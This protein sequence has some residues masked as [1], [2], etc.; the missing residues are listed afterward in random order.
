MKRPR[1]YVSIVNWKQPEATIVCLQSLTQLHQQGVRVV[2][3]DNDSRDNSAVQIRAAFPDLTLL[4]APTNLGFAGG[5]QLA[6]DEVILADA[7][8]DLVWLLN[9]DTQVY[10]NTL[11][12]LIAAY[13]QHGDAVYG[14][15]GLQMDDPT[16]IEHITGH[17]LDAEG[18]PIGDPLAQFDGHVADA[19]FTETEP[20][21][22]TDVTGSHW[23][24]PVSVIQQYGFMDTWYFM[25]AEEKAYCYD[26]RLQ[27]G[28]PSILVPK[29]RVMHTGKGSTNG[30]NRLR[31]VRRYYMRRNNLYFLRQHDRDNYWHELKYYARRALR[32]YAGRLDAKNVDD[33]GYFWADLMAIRDVLL[34]RRGKTRDPGRYL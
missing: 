31:Y 15:V 14:G 25:Y 12:H 21:M 13:L 33:P 26:L 20:M 22:V 32:Y 24:I 11:T 8:A 9:N 3:V 4:Q 6:L 28:V 23:M 29:S 2:V 5:H 34:N 17:R 19:V 1:V 18:K 10:P 30:E 27:H 16:R 7:E